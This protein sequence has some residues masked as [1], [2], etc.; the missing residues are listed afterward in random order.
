MPR[1]QNGNYSLP[2]IYVAVTGQT[3]MAEQHNIPLQDIARA[4]TGSL[5]RNGS[6]PMGANL[7]MAG[8]RITQLGPGTQ[9]TDAATV[10]QARADGMP[11]GAVIDFAGTQPPAGWLLCDG[12]VLMSD[13][14]YQELRQMLIDD[15]FL[16]G[17]DGNGN[18]KI[19][20]AR[21]R[22]TAGRDNMG[23]TSA[24]RLT[25]SG[26]GI[27]G[28]KVGATGGSETHKLNEDEMP[29]HRHTGTTNSAGQHR[30]DVNTGNFGQGVSSRLNRSASENP[31]SSN[32][33]IEPAGA[34]THTFT[35]NSA[36]GGK[37]HR[38]TQP[39]IIMN[40]IIKAR[41]A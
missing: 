16:H 29:A 25:S 18:P 17:E 22:V 10:G 38:N 34:H 20:D 6:A 30:H 11:I 36:G 21:G 24:N 28:T 41:Y 33:P 2:P 8:F 19:P 14:P 13:T 4:L 15:G 40:K 12:R 9:L 35:T 32:A 26:S 31:Q 39:T 3:V 23:G 37:P 27:D 7:P 5:P 1:D